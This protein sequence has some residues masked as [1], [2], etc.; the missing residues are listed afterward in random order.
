MC[1]RAI[2]AACPTEGVVLNP[3]V[4]SESTCVAAK[5]L[6]RD[7]I[8]FDLNED[9]LAEAQERVGTTVQKR[10]TNTSEMNSPTHPAQHRLDMWADCG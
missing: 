5:K 6:G 2:Q 10:P 3:F 8:W 4:G 7:F 1:T 9:Y